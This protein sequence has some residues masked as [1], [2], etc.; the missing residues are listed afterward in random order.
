MHTN[1]QTK[2][3]PVSY[4]AFHKS[5]DHSRSYLRGLQQTT[6]AELLSSFKMRISH[7]QCAIVLMNLGLLSVSCTV[8][9]PCGHVSVL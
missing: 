6:T 1:K 7:P 2:S 8:C 9:Y 4:G 3:S 5:S